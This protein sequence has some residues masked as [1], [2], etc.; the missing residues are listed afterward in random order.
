MLKKLGK[1]GDTIVE[2][3]I[4][5]SIV[6]LTIAS[7]YAIGSRSLKAARQA[8]ERGEAIKIAEAQLEGIK[9]IV[10]SGDKAKINAL[11]SGPSVFCVNSGEV[12]T[13]ISG[14]LPTLDSDDLSGYSGDC[15]SNTLYHTS[16]T[17]DPVGNDVWQFTA[18]VRWF[19]IG[20]SDKEELVINYRAYSK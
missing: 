17:R 6:G 11:K 16:V 12:K 10:D 3:M 13:S 8:Q 7:A 18:S 4:A 14:S 19:S 1:T 2:V 15:I 5:V 20:D 9:A